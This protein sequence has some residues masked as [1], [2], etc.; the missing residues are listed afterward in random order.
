MQSPRRIVVLSDGTGN[1]AS[2]VWRTNVWRVYQALELSNGHQ[3]ALYDDGVG[4]SSFKPLAIIGGAFGWG[5]KRNVLDLY[6]FVCRNYSSGAEIFAFGFSRGAFTIRVLTGLIAHEGLVPVESEEQLRRDSASA[7]RSY[8]KRYNSTGGLVPVFRGL[9][10]AVIALW[11]RVRGR[12]TYADLKRDNLIRTVDRIR[13]LGLWDT[14]SAYGLPID[15]MT[16]GVDFWFW[17]MSPPDRV[18]SSKVERACHALALDDARTTFHPML[19]N[20]AAEPKRRAAAR[21]P[22]T[23]DERISQ[24]WFT[25]MHSNVGGGYPDDA[26]AQ[27][28][29]YWIM[30]EARLAGLELKTNPDTV[31]AA[32]SSSDQDG[33][34][35]DSRHGLGGSY[36]YGP[37]KLLGVQRDAGVSGAI[38]V[39]PGLLHQGF[40]RDRSDEV[41]INEPKIHESVLQRITTGARAYAPIN[42]PESYAVVT[43]D[44]RICEPSANPYETPSH[45]AARV[46]TQERIWDIVWQ[47]RVVY[48][49]SFFAAAYLAV[50][51]WVH[52]RVTPDLGSR[53]SV[54]APAIRALAAA[55]PSFAESWIA[56]F[57]ASPG[58]FALGAALLAALVAR[59]ASLEQKIRDEMRAVWAPGAVKGQLPDGWIFRLR[60]NPAYTGFILA[61]KHYVLPF[62]FAWGV[63]APLL[64]MAVTRPWF[65]VESSFGFVCHETQAQAPF[66][67]AS[68]CWPTGTV[69]Q[70]GAR[71]RVSIEPDEWHD[72]GS[73]PVD[74]S[75]GLATSALPPWAWVSVLFRRHL[76]ESWFHPIARI[77]RTGN[78]ETPL[79]L[80]PVQ[81]SKR[82]EAEI[83]ARTTGMLFLYVNDGALP[84]SWWTMPYYANNHGT[85]AVTVT[86][87]G[88]GVRADE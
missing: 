30:R 62:V 29:L 26:L 14:V 80:R 82:Y 76:F 27:V 51:P 50:F 66:D 42:L 36:R 24:V 48:F 28:S 22:R 87:I 65:A 33:R 73:L 21:E 83:V 23:A 52:T 56:A 35:Y 20:E 53:F 61:M 32:R 70:E 79:T 55:L 17:P 69:V 67:T 75:L 72:G 6:R 19:W 88:R 77:G 12:R 78:D 68:P 46:L 49:A 34:L 9:R 11:Q 5:L 25:G 3:V 41:V 74:P 63:V 60:T 71:Y 18:L 45:A 47:R 84:L 10:D 4:T 39:S 81:G 44:G 86:E 85:A 8:R 15:E 37:R 59:G 54:L 16:R 7:Y 31:E 13:F 64:L 38:T 58:W 57:A 2:A 43:T 1:S 40:L